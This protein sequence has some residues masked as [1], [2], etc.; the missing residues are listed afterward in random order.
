ME[1]FMIGLFIIVLHWMT[2][3][4]MKNVEHTEI[5]V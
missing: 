2:L 5:T 4:T 1:L 3:L